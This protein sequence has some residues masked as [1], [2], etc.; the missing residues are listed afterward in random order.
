V[1]VLT[2]IAWDHINVFP[3][4]ENYVQQFEKF[5]DTIEP[6]GQLFYYKH[7][8]NLV[9]I[10]GRNPRISVTGYDLPEYE[11]RNGVT[12]LM[13]K[14]KT[15]PLHVFGKHNLQNIC[16]AWNICKA[17]D[18][19]DEDFL[20]HIQSFKG[21]G[22]RLEKIAENANLTVFKDFAHSP[23]KLKATTQAVK[24]QFPGKEL[25]AVMELHTFSSLNKKFLSEYKNSMIQADKAF[26]YYNPHTIA[27][28]RLEQISPQEVKQAFGGDNLQVFQDSNA[29]F[30]H[31][32]KLPLRNSVLLIMSSGNFNGVNIDEF[33]RQLVNTHND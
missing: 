28:K 11:I 6:G 12:Y 31:I 27:H 1:A 7:D 14:D 29:L 18:I 2:G 8:D 21:A 24:E 30:R 33:A 17:L 9:K 13:Y 3:T 23:S 16:A 19:K 32:E 22:K 25:I 20:T 5:I 26:V 4:F 15:Y 10:A